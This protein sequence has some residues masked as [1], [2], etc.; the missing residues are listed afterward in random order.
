MMIRFRVIIYHFVTGIWT[1]FWL[2]IVFPMHGAPRDPL[3]AIPIAGIFTLGLGVLF[4]K[5]VSFAFF[6]FADDLRRV[7]PCFRP[8]MTSVHWSL[9]MLL[10]FTADLLISIQYDALGTPLGILS[11]AAAAA[12]FILTVLGQRA[13]WR[14]LPKSAPDDPEK[15]SVGE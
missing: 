14:N 11:P 2:M 1:L 7:R 6:L 13:I 3:Y 15:G 9:H 5:V 8:G 4:G 12:A 10:F